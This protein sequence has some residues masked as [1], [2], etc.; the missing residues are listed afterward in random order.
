MTCDHAIEARPRPRGQV[1]L[2]EVAQHICTALQWLLSILVHRDGHA[3]K[4]I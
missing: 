2:E 1:Q 4:V 3:L